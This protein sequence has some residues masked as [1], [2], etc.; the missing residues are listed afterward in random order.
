MRTPNRHEE[1]MTVTNVIHFTP[2]ADLDAQ[3]NLNAF[4]YV[5]KE[6]LTVFGADLPFEADIWDLSSYV[7]LKAK[8]TAFRISFSSWE[9]DQGRAPQSMR[10]PFL[11]FAKSFVRFQHAMRPTRAMGQRIAALCA[12]EAALVEAGS[13]SPVHARSET[14]YRAAQLA[15][16]RFTPA[17]AYRIGA[18]LEAISTFVNEKRLTTVPFKWHNPLKRPRDDSV[19]VGKEF[20]DRRLKKLPSP[21][22]LN[23]L[24]IAFRMASS[25]RDLVATSV[26]AILCS[27]PDRINEALL[28]EEHCEVNQKSATSMDAEYGLRWRPSKGADPMVKWVVRSM[29]DVVREAVSRLRR[30]SEPA[31]EIARWYEKH[32]REIFLPPSL[33]CQRR[34]AR[35]TMEQL[36]QVLFVDGGS[37]ESARVWCK[38]KEIEVVGRRGRQTASFAKVERAVLAMLPARFPIADADL[39]LRYSQMLCVVRK[40]ELNERATYRCLIEQV[41]Q[42]Q[43]YACL[44]GGAAKANWSVFARFGLYEGDGKVVKIASHQL[45]HYLNTLAQIGG[46]SQLDIAKWSGRT[47]V[48]QNTAYDHESSRDIAEHVRKISSE[49]YKPVGPLARLQTKTL[50]PRDEFARLK[51]P[52]AHSTE[53]GFCVHDFTMTPCQVHRDCMNCDEQVCVKGDGFHELNLR[54]HREETRALL[55][56]AKTGQSEGLA[57]A[58]RWLEHQTLTLRRLD[59]LCQILDDPE[60]PVGAL[61]QPSGIV[62]ASRI[63]QAARNRFRLEGGA[64]DSSGHRLPAQRLDA[65]ASDESEVNEWPEQGT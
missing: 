23:A 35:I 62:P 7:T 5:C 26:A 12:L 55:N 4:V 6:K 50:I 33:E 10:E 25:P 21:E 14:F 20:D 9:T 30:I 28:L 54:R 65:Q 3:A 24:A 44:S 47:D 58:D 56:S 2:R 15:Q 32:P 29:A 46:L 31:R 22:A 42:G 36:A 49:E 37:P 41:S 1:E 16:E 8:R 19:R 51:I 48:K 63:E 39:D 40:N 27:A 45:R 60:V 18:Q 17:V 59:Q 53:F 43:I 52:T 11:S 61:I 38:S 13:P 34:R 57:G 64:L